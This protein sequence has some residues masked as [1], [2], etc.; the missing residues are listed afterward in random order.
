MSRRTR[1]G[2]DG[3]SG[4]RRG[5]ALCLVAALCVG[6]GGGDAPH[7]QPPATVANPRPEADL[8]TVRL[9]EDAERR[10]GVTVAEVAWREVPRTRTVGGEI[11]AAP[12][13]TAA[14]AAPVA[15]TLLAPAGGGVPGVGTTVGR[16]QTVFRLVVLVGD[17]SLASAEQELLAADA[18]ARQARARADRA[19]E[20]LRQQLISVQDEETARADAEAA[21][22]T[23][24]AARAQ[25]DILRGGA[26]TEGDAGTLSLVAPERGILRR[27]LAAPGQTVAAGTPLFEVVAAAPAWVRVPL[28][29]GDLADVAPGA[30]ARV[31]ALG[32]GATGA[33]TWARAVRGPPVADPAA[34]SADLYFELDAAAAARVGQR[35]VVTLTLRGRE[36]RLAAPWSAV[37]FDAQGGSWMYERVAPLTYARRRVAVAYVSGDVAVLARGPAPGTLVVATGVAEL[38]G[39]EFGG[40]K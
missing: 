31:H 3:P 1:V 30:G 12:G 20:L 28:Y 7:A 29:V 5:P 14:V 17:R 37:V 13:R 16:S 24:R 26:D 9:T 15:G 40:G 25:V 10:L 34:A 2:G 6:C 22:A 19:R 33:G 23:F 8:A 11:V 38:F 4:R 32:S 21:E 27:L 39:T 18:R 36:R 35:V